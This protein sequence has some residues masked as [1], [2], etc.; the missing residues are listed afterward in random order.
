MATAQDRNRSSGVNS[1]A[2][3]TYVLVTHTLDSFT[4]REMHNLAN[5]LEFAMITKQITNIG[6][7]A[8]QLHSTL[9]RIHH[10]MH[11]I[12]ARIADYDYN[13]IR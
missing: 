10:Y 5:T 11:Y 13:G 4:K 9:R 6:V 8:H 2:A 7:T 1:P 3:V 12:R